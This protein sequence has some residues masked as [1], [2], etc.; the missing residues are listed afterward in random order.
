MKS[1]VTSFRFRLQESREHRNLS[2]EGNWIPRWRSEDQWRDTY[3]EAPSEGT[4]KSQTTQR[5][6]TQVQE[7]M[8][9]KSRF[10][11]V[12]KRLTHPKS[13][14]SSST[15]WGASC[16][17]HGIVQT[18]SSSEDKSWQPGNCKRN[19]SCTWYSRTFYDTQRLRN[20]AYIF[21]HNFN[22]PER[23]VTNC[24]NITMH[25]DVNTA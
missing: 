19:T 1:R 23:T 17:G 21:T 24:M 8:N 18:R 22:N 14:M 9:E 3:P 5:T 25:T 7:D 4:G 16:R 13:I 6:E 15:S 10:A 11:E 12:T 2:M 20:T